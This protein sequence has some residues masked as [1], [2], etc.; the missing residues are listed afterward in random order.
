MEGGDLTPDIGMTRVG[1]RFDVL[2]ALVRQG[3]LGGLAT[4][5]SVIC[6]VDGAHAQTTRTQ[7]RLTQ[8]QTETARTAQ[9]RLIVALEAYAVQRAA[10]ASA[11]YWA[12]MRTNLAR[13][14]P[15]EKVTAP[16]LT[17]TVQI[18]VQDRDGRTARIVERILSA[19]RNN[20]RIVGGRPVRANEFRNVVAVVRGE[21]P[22]CTGTLIGRRAVLTAAHCVCSLRTALE[23]PDAPDQIV[24]GTAVSATETARFNVIGFNLFAPDFCT[25]A[26]SPV[27][28]RDLAIV[29]FQDNASSDAQRLILPPIEAAVR[30]RATRPFAGI[31][32]ASL[33]GPSLLFA[34][35]VTDMHLVGFGFTENG[36]SGRK[37][38]AQTAIQSLICGPP[39]SAAVDC[40]AGREM[41]LA[42]QAGLGDNCRGDSG[43][44]AFIFYN[45]QIYLAAVTSRAIDPGGQC[46]VG[47]IY[48][49]ITPGVI[50]WIAGQLSI[51]VTV[52]DASGDCVVRRSSG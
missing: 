2:G 4:V 21:K 42:D 36:T 11:R 45:N 13:S 31:L 33:A 15:G 49:L 17:D 16:S 48:S 43:G 28:G 10:K 39:I 18:T 8:P 1:L 3:F 9:R 35:A 34:A 38:H 22:Y 29:H 30:D 32:V 44:P 14:A 5:M 7:A 37:V 12:I 46:G 41:M 40:K 50:S 24:F 47:G 26:A 20:A 52:C 19:A 27:A 6:P 25:A 51:N 23:T